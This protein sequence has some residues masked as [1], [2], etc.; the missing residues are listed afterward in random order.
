MKKIVTCIL[1]CSFT[2]VY[3]QE[4]IPATNT[5]MLCSLQHADPQHRF[6]FSATTTAK[7][8]HTW[9]YEI[10]ADGKLLFHQEEMPGKPKG[11]GFSTQEDA[12]KVADFIISLLKNPVRPA[13]AYAADMKS[14]HIL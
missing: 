14:M 7:A 6:I 9:G 3:G 5:K 10:F 13:I 4:V 2:A 1:F 12:L 8:D 11:V